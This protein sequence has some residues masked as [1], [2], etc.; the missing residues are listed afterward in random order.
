M[1]VSRHILFTEKSKSHKKRIE[2]KTPSFGFN[3]LTV[4]II[5]RTNYLFIHSSDLKKLTLHVGHF[6]F[7]YFV[8]AKNSV[9]L[10]TIFLTPVRL[11]Q[12]GRKANIIIYEIVLP[13]PF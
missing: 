1:G 11:S 13:L 6:S 8:K 9:I 2:K 4:I 5:I 10:D 12:N 3:V 7:D